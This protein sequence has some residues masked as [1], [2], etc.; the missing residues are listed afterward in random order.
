MISFTHVWDLFRFAWASELTAWSVMSLLSSLRSDRIKSRWSVNTFVI[1]WRICSID[2][3]CIFFIFLLSTIFIMISHLLRS[4][5]KLSLKCYFSA[6]TSSLVMSVYDV[7]LNVKRV[8]FYVC[9]YLLS[10]WMNVF[11]FMYILRKKHVLIFVFFFFWVV[12]KTL[13]QLQDY[14]LSWMI[15]ILLLL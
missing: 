12:L 14:F 4:D 6:V 15:L 1:L 7:I 11:S 5:D 2:F 8:L 13:N 10:S 3:F 9:N